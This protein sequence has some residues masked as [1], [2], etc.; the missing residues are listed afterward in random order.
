MR[1]I[2]FKETE[3]RARSFSLS[4]NVILG[5]VLFAGIGF[6]A[7]AYFVYRLANKDL[8]ESQTVSLLQ[9][10]IATDRATLNTIKDQSTMEMAAVGR[11][12]ATMQARLL[13]MEALGQ[14]VTEV[15]NID[16]SEFRFNEAP[17]L[18]GPLSD[19]ESKNLENELDDTDILATVISAP[20]YLLTVDHLSKQLKAREDQLELL[21][22]LLVRRKFQNDIVLA[23]RPISKGWMSSRFGRRVDPITGAMAWHAGVD[24]AGREGADVIAVASGVVVFAD[25]RSGYGKMV[26]LNHGGGYRTRYGHHQTLFVAAGDVVKRGQ[27]IG[28]IGSTGRSTGPHVHFEVLKNGKKVDPKR[29]VARRSQ[30]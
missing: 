12:L 3:G 11:R 13:R 21:E 16:Q 5:C 6:I 28:S 24:F 2:L 9:Q 22:S 27:V 20:E 1:I 19:H 7:N 30:S 26:E 10:Q 23:G 17:A 15:A 18:G 25:V 14:R 8:L 4:K 29:Y